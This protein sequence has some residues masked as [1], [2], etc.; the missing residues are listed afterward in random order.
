MKTYQDLQNCGEDE[1]KRLQF[2]KNA[3][4]EFRGTS[5][6]QKARAGSAYYNKCNLTIEKFKKILTTLSGRMVEDVFSSNYKLKT[7]FFRRLVMQQVQYVLGNGLILQNKENK[8]KL[9]KNFDFMLQKAA[10]IAMAQ[11]RAI[12]FWNFD[13]MEVF[14]YADTEQEPGFLPLYNGETAILEAGIRYWYRTIGDKK[15]LYMT[16]YE[17]DGYTE[18]V[19]SEDKSVGEI[20]SAKKPYKVTVT[21]TKIGGIEK[22]EGENYGKLPI[23]ILYANDTKESE[24]EGI[25]ESIDCYDFVKSG[26]ANDIDDTAGFYWILKNTGGMEDIE[27]AEFIQRMK[28][29]RAAVVDGDEGATAEAHT[30]NIPVEARS[31]MLEILRRDIYED[32]QSLDLT[33]L[34]AAQKTTQEIQA[35]YQ[36]Q[37]NKCADFEYFMIEFVEGIMQLAGISDEPTFLWNKVVNVKEQTETVLLASEY[38]TEDMIIKKLPF[39]TP[40]EADSVLEHKFFDGGNSFN[41]G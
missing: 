8:S 9:G 38:L 4:A 19:S 16:L 29:V 35:A 34:S 40:E 28:T 11:G 24:L 41:G 25:R 27:L 17:A 18:Y 3:I 32:F 26:L 6:Y 39:L 30:L 2:C 15:T 14:S 21:R 33:Q 23:V 22:V 31:K 37:D 36:L 13:H 1:K 10:K 12:G 5:S 20:Q 7:Q